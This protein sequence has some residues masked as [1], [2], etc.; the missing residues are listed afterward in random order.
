MKLFSSENATVLWDL[1]LSHMPYEKHG[2]GLN[3]DKNL[4]KIVANEVISSD[5]TASW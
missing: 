5:V 3:E 1:I 2:S 4:P